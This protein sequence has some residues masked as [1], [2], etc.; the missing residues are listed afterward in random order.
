[1]G[2]V[3]RWVALV[4]ILAVGMLQSAGAQQ[5]AGY[6]DFDG[7]D[8]YL[9]AND[10]DSLSFGNGTTDSPM[11]I[12]M[13]F[14]PDTMAQK[15]TLI[16]KW[17]DGPNQE[18]RLYIASNSVRLDLYDASTTAMVSSF[19]PLSLTGWHHLAA[20]YDGRGGA[21][22]ADGIAIYIDGAAV[23]S[24]PMNDA[25]Y[26]AME[27][28]AVP[29]QIGRE[30]PQW[31]QYDGSLDDVRLWNVARSVTQIQAFRSAE[32]SGAQPGL[33]AYW[34][35]NDG[36]GTSAADVVGSHPLTLFNNPVWLTGGPV[37]PADPDVTL[38]DI[39]NISTSNLSDT[40]ITIQFTTNEP[41]T[42][43][44]S[45]SPTGTCPCVD[46]YS[47]VFG[48]AHQVNVTG[49]IP[50]TSYTFVVHAT[51]GGANTQTAAPASFI[52]LTAPPDSV[53]PAVS[54][55]APAAGFVAGTINVSAT[56]SD[57]GGVAGVQFR[58][59]GVNLAAEDVTPPYAVVWDTLL[60]SEGAHTLTAVA[61]DNAGNTA[62]A[63][64]AV[65]VRNQ[66]TAGP[67][68]LDFDG[69]DDYLTG[70]DAN[71]LSFGN[72]TTDFPFTIETWF[73]P[74]FMAGK[75]TL[76]GKWLDG[77]NQE[78]RLYIASN[79]I[80]LDLFD[81]SAN[82]MASAFAPATL[83]GWH[84]LAVT[85]DGRGGATAAAG[86]TIF[87]DG[88]P[89]PSFQINQPGYVAMENTAVALQVGRE[90]PS[91]QQYNGSLDDMRLWN[92]ARSQSQIQALMNGEL[93]SAQPGLV[94]YWKFND[95]EGST[96]A[97]TVGSHPL[98]LNG[99]PA[100]LAGG[101][102][103]PAAPDV[104][105][106]D[107]TQIST[108]NH[109]SSGITIQFSTNEPTS[110]R[111]SLST[112]GSCPCVDYSSPVFGVTHQVIISGLAASTTYTYVVHATDAA[113]NSQASTPA[114]FTTPAVP[115]DTQPPT[116][117][118]TAPAAGTVAGTVTV[119]ATAADAS[120]IAGVQFRL[121]GVNLAAEDVAAPYSVS[122]NTLPVADG[123]H[124]LTAIARD[125]AGNAATATL[126][127]T[128]R[129]QVT[130]G[131]PWYLDF[132][133]V[134][135]YLT[136]ADANSLSFGNGTAD[137]PLTFE[138]WI[139]PDAMTGKRSL[140]SKWLDSPSQEYR[141]YIASHSLRLD[142][143][144]GSSN[145]TSSAFAPISLTGW[146]HVAATYDGRGGATAANGITIYV[147]GAAI[148]LFPSNAAGY[149]AMENTTVPVTIGHEGPQW[150]QYDGSLDDLRIWNVVRTPAQIQSAMSAELT[151]AEAGLIAYWKF[152]EGEGTTAADSDTAGAHP[153]TLSAGPTWS[154][155]GPITSPT[156]QAPAITS[157]ALATL[158]VG[159]AG[160]FVVTTTGAPAPTLTLVGTLPSGIAFSDLGDGTATLS[161]TA[162]A[163]TGGLYT[164]TITAM[165]GSG[166][167]A[168]QSFALTI[169]QPPAIT[170]AASTRFRTGMAGSFQLTSTGFPGATFGATG[171]M[172]SGVTLT[173]GANGTATLSGTPAATAG[174]A[175]NLSLTASNGFGT[176]ASQS[177]TLYVDQPPAITSAATAAFQRGVPGSFLVTTA[178]FPVASLTATGALPEGLAFADQGNG[179]ATVSGTPSMTSGGTYPLTVTASNGV[180]LNAVQTL[181]VSIPD[182]VL[183]PVGALAAADFGTA[184]SVTF[185][186]SGGTGFGFSLSSGSL[187]AGLTLTSGGVLSGTPTTTGSFTF[188]VSA[189]NGSGCT[190]TNLYALQV[191]PRAQNETFDNAVG[192]T[193]YSVGAGIPS[194]PAVVVSGSVL[195]NDAGPGTLTA[196]PASIA[197]ANGGHVAMSASGTFLY[198]P[199]VGF[200]GPSDSFG[201][202]LTDGNGVTDNAVVTINLGS[203]V[204][205]VNSAAAAGDGRSHSPFNAM[206]AAATAAQANQIV[207]VH[208][209]SP[210]G[211]YTAKAGQTV[212]GAGAA[213]N[214]RGL[215]ITAGAHPLVQGTIVL[216]D[217]TLIRALRVNGGA[218]AAIS[219]NG[220]TGTETL[221][222]VSIT[223]GATGLDLTNVGGTLNMIGGSIAGVT[224]GADVRVNGGSGD[225]TIG[226]SIN[227]TGGRSVDIQHRRGGTIA[228]QGAIVDRGAGVLLNDNAG[229]VINFTG[230]LDLV[231]TNDIAFAATAGGTVT[232]TQNNVTIVNTIATSATTALNITNT[233]IGGAGATFRS[234]SSGSGEFSAATG[235]ILDN[236]GVAAAN[237][238]LTVTGNGTMQSGGVIARKT[239]ANGSVAEGVGI[240][241]N[242][243]K[244]P[245]FSWMDLSLFDNSAIVG[246][247]VAGFL[248]ANSFINTAGNTAGIFEGPIVFGRPDAGG[249][250]G[251]TGTGVIR[252]SQIVGGFSD[253]VAVYNQSGVLTLAVERTTPTA[254]DCLIGFNAPSTGRH[255]LVLQMEGTANA[256]A[257][258]NMCRFRDNRSTGVMA[259]AT[260]A[261]N[262]NLV[263]TGS[264]SDPSMTTE[265]V[266]SGGGQ[267]VDGV[268]VSNSGSAS[269]TARIENGVYFGLTGAAVRFG[270]ADNTATSASRLNVTVT[271]S[272]VE[273]TLAGSEGITGRFNSAPGQVAEASV[274]LANNHINQY[275]TAPAII[276]ATVAGTPRVDLAL[277]L[278][279]VDMRELTPGSGRGPIGID[280]TALN[281]SMCGSFTNNIA[282]LYPVDVSPQ[283]GGI[284]VT[285]SG[286]LFRLE[287]GLELI[288]ASAQTVLSTN[289]PAPTLSVMITQAIGAFTVV[290]NG[291]CVVPPQGQ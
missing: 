63:T 206:P 17:F 125:T 15:R 162:A 75:Q 207:Y 181:S 136:A 139:R 14:R 83:S 238:G 246:R 158:Q 111:V 68:Y 66:F 186:A 170:S 270:Q 89:L 217:N 190:A 20:T 82:A 156:S 26:V 239:G 41:T 276:L 236:T 211:S 200:A 90:G 113:N 105:A 176:Q 123:P 262:L 197:S 271:G 28:T 249:T 278:N 285:Q 230:G 195:A 32:L 255:G 280:V 212:W 210:P 159:V 251:L 189:T 103:A 140:V 38:P 268:A 23:Q 177:F 67:W 24:F 191:A 47:P 5:V 252:D 203:V 29:L 284:R 147:D 222:D 180:G 36:A 34:K 234:I 115:T 196:G 168:S 216:A 146:H 43:W 107:I 102:V 179:T 201:Y 46:I 35:F 242:N 95:G 260:G 106:P 173:P 100:W 253:N 172:P 219:A 65:T 289:N 141:F 124:T 183:L 118:F 133:G 185:A 274:V 135:D 259:T 94:A 25:G 208:A 290:E 150:Q 92:V 70:A 109:T 50:D 157:S 261:A 223:G 178:G 122:W 19:A 153:L 243:T 169:A 175:Y 44:V 273:S 215:T 77:P 272:L 76:L 73:R 134:D 69:V 64:R 12:E 142:L 164:P 283:G 257:T 143:H 71:S 281:A 9:S 213:F 10:A 182:C 52:T 91:W 51:D 229:A 93:S 37:T 99:N 152:N 16:G 4:V 163:A 138:M 282:H 218:G 11:T 129:N 49:L 149:V 209:G 154:P 247:N 132:D 85:Y 79:S 224:A 98:T 291:T 110:G 33:V 2:R 288:S 184:Y 108:A 286:G 74:D 56:A 104:T 96:A 60:A 167:A 240:Y 155:G 116:V 54:F 151:G 130:A 112:T 42:G 160:S 205:Y 187:P 250:N 171:T 119:S 221:N 241:L 84:H 199:P 1:M 21:T 120:G 97:D 27:N 57:A 277:D 174:G 220:L 121:D 245:S 31:Q 117:S 192:N 48:V 101:P 3:V 59:D 228:L 114:T 287:R 267:G 265:F 226:A 225:M 264:A 53:P 88:A 254:G 61:R 244:N 40:G 161:G 188:G 87:V 13:W 58:L 72:G 256:S 266:H 237:G 62:T 45:L 78:Y 231:T 227:N 232:V 279:H 214:I 131:G 144:D 269:L 55:T 81:S 235:I 8:D 7:V 137:T 39:T 258:V 233:Q 193:Q 145:A 30:G 275:G 204:W 127:V 165:N 18:Y 194:T 80:R 126:A 202:T 86:I 166:P 248:L 6:L 22:A 128:V 148:Q 263:V 198:T